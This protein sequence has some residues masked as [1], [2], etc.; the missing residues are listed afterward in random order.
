MRCQLYHAIFSIL[1]VIQ[2]LAVLGKYYHC[3]CFD[4]PTQ[5]TYTQ[6]YIHVKVQLKPL[7]H[8]ASMHFTVIP[9]W[10]CVNSY[11]N[12]YAPFK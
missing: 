4:V 12:Y 10:L 1:A 7:G 5:K 3:F 8:D 9:D 2:H 11:N 6:Q